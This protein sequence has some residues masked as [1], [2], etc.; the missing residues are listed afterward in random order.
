M[1]HEVQ[2]KQATNRQKIARQSLY[3]AATSL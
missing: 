1:L 2:F 3:A